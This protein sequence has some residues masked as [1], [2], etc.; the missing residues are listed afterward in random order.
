MDD[1]D[2]KLRF[3]AKQIAWIVVMVLMI[4]ICSAGIYIGYQYM[5]DECVRK[6]TYSIALDWW[7]IAAC[8]YDGVFWLIVMTLLCCRARQTCR[9]I[10]IWPLNFINVVW[11]GIGIW[12]LVE[13][14]IRCQ[15]NILWVMSLVVICITLTIAF[16]ISVVLCCARLGVCSSLGRYI[17][18]EETPYEHYRPIQRGPLQATDWVF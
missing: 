5:N 7:L 4:P 6:T 13:S 8:I 3:L 9:R 14:Q 12:L 2:M 11:M 1:F 17:S 16:A 10:V 15:H 18:L